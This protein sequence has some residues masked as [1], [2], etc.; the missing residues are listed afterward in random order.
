MTFDAHGAAGAMKTNGTMWAWGGNVGIHGYTVDN[1]NA[2]RS[3]PVQVG[4][5]SPYDKW[6][7]IKPGGSLV[8]F[9]KKANVDPENGNDL[10]EY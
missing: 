8:L 9:I 2:Y 10:P 3:S 6:V 7:D 5:I 4:Y 1:S